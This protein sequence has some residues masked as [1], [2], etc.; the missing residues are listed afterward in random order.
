MTEA[1]KTIQFN[2]GRK[3][4]A[5][6]QIITATLYADGIVTFM[7]HSRLI[8]GEFKLPLHCTF[9]QIEVMHHYDA[10][11]YAY[12]S[13]SRSRAD[14]LF[15]GGRNTRDGFDALN[16]PAAEPAAEPETFLV[17]GEGSVELGTFP[18]ETEARA[19]VAGYTRA[20]DW[21]GY[22]FIHIE[23]PVTGEAWTFTAP[24]PEEEPAP[25]LPAAKYPDH[26]DAGEREIIDAI[27]TKALDD[28]CTIRVDDE[29]GLSID[30]TDDRAL[31]TA[32]VGVT[33]MT[34][35]CFRSPEWRTAPKGQG[36]GVVWLIHG[37]GEHVLSDCTD[38]DFT[39]ALVA[40]ADPII[41]RLEAEGAA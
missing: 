8:D 10:V 30:Y 1:I 5:E 23:N 32:N 27:I 11:T 29:E 37:N 31:I 4:T 9:N 6:G 24:E 33:D 7:D 16:K 17:M 35:L 28:G 2:T 38:N 36:G 41:D 34:K 14:G 39:A 40:V 18:T 21:G 13:T 22:T 26:L 19:F 12:T 3:Y 15:K 20:G 25:E